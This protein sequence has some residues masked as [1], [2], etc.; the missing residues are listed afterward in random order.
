MSAATPVDDVVTVV[1]V[2]DPSLRPQ[3]LLRHAGSAA[4][5]V[6]C[7]D[8]HLRPPSTVPW[9]YEA[10]PAEVEVVARD[11]HDIE[12]AAAIA[13][14]RTLADRF[15]D[16]HIESTAGSRP[17][18]TLPGGWV[19]DDALRAA[20]ADDDEPVPPPFS[21]PG[22]FRA[23]AER[24]YWPALRSSRPDLAAAFPIP[25]GDD[26]FARW[27][28]R[29]CVVDETPLLVP[30][31]PATPCAT[32]DFALAWNDSPLNGRGVN[33][34]GYLDREA[35]LGDVARRLA[36]AVGAA[37]LPVRRVPSHRTSSPRLAEPPSL[38]AH[39]DFAT[40]IAVIN[41]DQFAGLRTDLPALWGNGRRLIGY[42]FW[43]LATISPAMRPALRLIDEVWVGSRFVGDAFRAASARPV[44]ELPL[45]VPQPVTS[46]R[47]R[48]E[49]P[50]LADAGDRPVFLVA[51]DHL[52][53][54]ERKNPIGAIRAFASAFARDEGP[55]LV[56]KSMNADRAPD[57]HRRVVGAAGDR[58]DIRVV[59]AHLDR[60]DQMALVACADALVSL[61]RSEG[62]GLHLAEAMWLGTPTIATRYS[63][64]LDFQDDDTAMLV[65][66]TLVP[67]TFGRGV[68]PEAAVWADPDLDAAATAMRRLV[69]DV[70]LRQRLA[71]AGRARMA[72]QPDPAEVGRR[73]VE[74]LQLSGDAQ[75]GAM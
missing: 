3:D 53:V 51:F 42:W 69:D 65:D 44:R 38:D 12:T 32:P 31:L 29:A 30:P 75:S 11:P 17:S 4:F 28:T 37:G 15:A 50:F 49:F 5:A 68:Y 36:D 20:V 47:V 14:Q 10:E 2:S 25:D 13:A 19:V 27:T 26:W 74:L 54:T 22:R 43:E 45:P 64:N 18:L 46:G 59:D 56:I 73:I 72:A 40:T 48:P 35:S 16:V 71:T 60:T 57:D 6:W 33:V 58:P 8:P 62:L 61:H 7:G 55:I 9:L 67:V 21:Q 1:V 52:S 39:P 63:G 41:A 24:H 23:W 34:V 70:R 66:A